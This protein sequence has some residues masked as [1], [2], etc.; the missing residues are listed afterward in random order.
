[1]LDTRTCGTERIGMIMW[2]ARI[3]EALGYARHLDMWHWMN[4]HWMNRHLDMLGTEA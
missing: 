2:D 3:C 4:R 1:M